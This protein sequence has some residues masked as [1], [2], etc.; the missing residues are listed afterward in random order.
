[1][2]YS[3][4][5]FI[6]FQFGDTKSS[7]L[8]IMRVSNGSRYEEDMIPSFKDETQQITGGDGTLYWD[9]FYTQKTHNIEIAFDSMTEMQMRQFR[10][11]FRADKVDKLIYN[12]SPYKYYY[13]KV[14]S[15]PQLKYICFEINGER[16]Y[17][18]EGTIKMISYD[19]FARQV[20]KY[21]DEYDSEEYPN[22]SQWAEVSGLKPTQDDYDQPGS[23]QINL[24]NAGDKPTDFMAYFESTSAGSFSLLELDGVSMMTLSGVELESGDTGFRVNSRARVIEGYSRAAG[25][26]AIHLTGTLYNKYI[27]AGDFFKI[28]VGESIIESNTGSQFYKF[29]YDYLYL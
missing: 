6:G 28:P 18:G 14:Q 9:S 25:S 4:L 11:T 17:K 29:E 3:D 27:T 22:K 23:S 16:I 24:Y 15:A 26:D 1:M 20:H 21:L 19:P 7:D 12:E 5:D 2:A 8:N 10:N 13:A